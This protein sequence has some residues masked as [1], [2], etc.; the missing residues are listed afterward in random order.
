[1]RRYRERT[2][3]YHAVKVAKDGCEDHLTAEWQ[4]LEALAK[5]DVTNVPRVTGWDTIHLSLQPVCVNLSLSPANFQAVVHGL[6]GAV[7]GGARAG[8]VHCDVRPANV[9]WDASSE[10]VVLLDWGCAKALESSGTPRKTAL[11]EYTGGV[12]CA[13]AGALG[14]IAD[15]QPYAM[16]SADDAVSVVKTLWRLCRPLLV[17]RVDEVAERARRWLRAWNELAGERWLEAEKV[18]QAC[19][20]SEEGYQQLE[21]KLSAIVGAELG[22]E[23]GDAGAAEVAAGMEALVLGPETDGGADPV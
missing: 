21:E 2:A 10:S 14:A 4:C 15:N 20:G 3:Q 11:V 6:V 12:S 7:A 18:A 13:S 22:E 9:M 16:S 17:V 1:M 5:L 23:M 8:Y 19:D